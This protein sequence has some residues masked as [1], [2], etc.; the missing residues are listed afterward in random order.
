MQLGSISIIVA[1]STN[2]VIGKD[3]D[4]PWN[5]PTD[6]KS[7]KKITGKAPVIM[8]RKCW[9]SIPSKYRPLPNRTNVVLSRNPNYKAD[10]AEVRSNLNLAIEEQ[11]WGVN[12]IFII[13]GSHIYKEAFGYADK[14]YMTVVLQE[15]EGDVKLEG[16]NPTEWLLTSSSEVMEE[17][18]F[19]FR[20]NEYDRRAKKVLG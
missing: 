4:I 12:E 17:N 11:I 18:G 6:L 9:E 14:L 19:K 16:Y 8:G 7:F 20:F 10:G 2:L 13:G 3:N 15:I 1:A 5:I